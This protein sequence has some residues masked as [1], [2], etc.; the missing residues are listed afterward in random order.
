MYRFIKFIPLTLILATGGCEKDNEGT[1]VP[2]PETETAA[3]PLN[4]GPQQPASLTGDGRS[5]CDFAYTMRGTSPGNAS[6]KDEDGKVVTEIAIQ[7]DESAC[8]DVN[9]EVE[10]LE[11]AKLTAPSATECISAVTGG[12]TPTVSFDHKVKCGCDNRW[13]WEISNTGPPVKFHVRVRPT[14]SCAT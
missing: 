13:E 1:N 3:K 14:A 4:T 12:E 7:V 6:L 8:P 2:K 9:I 5:E 11:G 10:H